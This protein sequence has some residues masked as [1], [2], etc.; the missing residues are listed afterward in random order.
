MYNNYMDFKGIL[1]V[2]LI[3]IILFMLFTPRRVTSI[4]FIPHHRRNRAIR[5]TSPQKKNFL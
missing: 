4:Q 3:V 5:R 2:I 1:Y